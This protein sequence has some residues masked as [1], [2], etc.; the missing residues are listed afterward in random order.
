MEYSNDV[1]RNSYY[2][3]MPEVSKQTEK[4]LQESMERFM[5]TN[6]QQNNTTRQQSDADVQNTTTNGSKAPSEVNGN[7][8]SAVHKDAHVD[9]KP[10]KVVAEPFD[11]QEGSRST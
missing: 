2:H 10:S 9:V 4:Y 3:R 6:A 7:G 1:S 8:T 5:K 11:K